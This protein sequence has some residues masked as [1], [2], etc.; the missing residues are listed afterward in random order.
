[1]QRWRERHPDWPY[2][3]KGDGGMAMI[4][5]PAVEIAGYRTGPAW[6]SERPDRAFHEFMAQWMDQPVDGALGGETFQGFRITVDYRA[7]TAVFER[8]F[9]GVMAGPGGESWGL[10]F[11]CF[12]RERKDGVEGKR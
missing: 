3:D 4:Q 10:A 11:Q 6:F 2:I 12:G 5:V 9:H 7:E 8:C 1:M